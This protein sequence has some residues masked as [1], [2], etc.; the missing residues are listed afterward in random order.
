[1]TIVAKLNIA[2]VQLTHPNDM[3]SAFVGDKIRGVA[4][5]VYVPQIASYY[6]YLT[7]YMQAHL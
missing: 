2:G 6:A 1:M 3:V 4:K 7:I 5:L